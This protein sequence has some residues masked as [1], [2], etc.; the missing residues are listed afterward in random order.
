MSSSV[1][2][3]LARQ[4]A[5][6]LGVSADGGQRFRLDL[7]VQRRRQANRPNHSQ[8]VFVESAVRVADG[9]KQSPGQVR[10]SAVRV[11][12]ERFLARPAAPGH[13]VD[14]EV[15]PGQV[16]LDR[17]AELDAVGV[18]VIR[19]RDVAAE[20]GYL[21]LGAGMTHDHGPE[22][23]LVQRAREQ[24][25][26]PVRRR[27]RR[28]VPIRGFAAEQRVA[29]AA[30]HDIG[31]VPASPESGQQLAQPGQESPAPMPAPAPRP[32]RPRDQWPRKRYERQLPLR[33][34]RRYGVKSE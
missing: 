16:L 8:G 34:S 32:P 22:P 33:S 5:R 20:R 30:A 19:V 11:D 31:G 15:A 27:V 2:D 10:A 14:G 7:E 12:E 18:A 29:Q 13:G 4:M 3:P 9:P 6:Q 21:V 24:A 26:D 1:S 28:Q 17:I 23:V 25:L